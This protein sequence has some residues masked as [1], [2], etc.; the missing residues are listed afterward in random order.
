MA[1]E[2]FPA[3]TLRTGWSC[4]KYLDSFSVLS[5]ILSQDTEYYD[6]SFHDFSQSL[7]VNIGLVTAIKPQIFS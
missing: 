3:L 2:Y 6:R 5:S 7:D 4:G 1:K